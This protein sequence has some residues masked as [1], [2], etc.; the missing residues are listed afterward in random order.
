MITI[1]TMTEA[2]DEIASRIA[3]ACYRFTAEPDQL[4]DE[5]LN[6][7]LHQWC[8][9][10]YMAVSRAK[11]I[12]IVAEIDG[13]VVGV[14][15][16]RGDSLMEMFVDLSYHRKGVGGALFRSAEQ[17]VASCGHSVV[18]V[19]T[20]NSALPF[21]AAMGMRQVQMYAPEAGAFVGTTMFALEKDIAPQ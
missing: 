10:A 15:A 18:R 3:A 7:A 2:D 21:Y 13:E 4:T 19:K 1:R 5:Q 11:D 14:A 20:T 8:T 16:T 12:A 6:G 9:S 17:T